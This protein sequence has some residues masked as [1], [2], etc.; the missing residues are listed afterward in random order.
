MRDAVAPPT[1]AQAAAEAD[2]GKLQ[3]NVVDKQVYGK[4]AEGQS[5]CKQR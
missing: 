3:A 4:A 5:T 1:A 2:L